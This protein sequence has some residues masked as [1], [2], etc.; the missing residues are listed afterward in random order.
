MEMI[1]GPPSM[2]ATTE[3]CVPTEI[4][5]A[6]E[7]GTSTP[8]GTATPRVD[9]PSPSNEYD[10][11]STNPPRNGRTDCPGNTASTPGASDTDVIVDESNAD[12]D[13]PTEPASSI[14][15]VTKYPN[16]GANVTPNDVKS[17]MTCTETVA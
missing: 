17:W 13:R 16:C 4:A 9:T 7:S 10:V 1:A 11:N 3:G 8:T 2:S 15:S 6:S 14:V 5:T 12:T